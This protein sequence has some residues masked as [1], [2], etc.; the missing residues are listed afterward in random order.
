MK[1]CK[2]VCKFVSLFLLVSLLILPMAASALDEYAPKPNEFAALSNLTRILNE[3]SAIMTIFAGLS[4]SDT[5]AFWM[6]IQVLKSKKIYNI[7]IW[8]NSPGGSAFDGLALSDEI[9]TAQDMGFNIRAYA[10]GIIA[11]A[12]VPVFA[13][14]K[15]R[16]A[17]PSTIFMVHEAALWKWPG[18]ET[19]SDIISQ[20]KL[21]N[22]L[23]ETY[24]NK[25]ARHS[26]L[27][28]E[29]W[30]VME[31]RTSWFSAL[32]AMSYGIVDVVQ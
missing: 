30:H 13:V 23:Q 27:S 17:K 24:L 31:A 14:C 22:L 11:S 21:M 26:K 2:S 25:L 7:D 4:V 12:A 3:N 19:H 5:R 9:I 8:I 10:S 15:Q 1:K 6:D 20:G 28:F 29:E 18:R 32:E 16:Y